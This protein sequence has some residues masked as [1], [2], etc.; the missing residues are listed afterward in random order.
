M[1]LLV[2]FTIPI[3]IWHFTVFVPDRFWGGIIGAFVAA[4]VGGVATGV[5]GQVLSGDPLSTT[6]IDTVLWTVPG[7]LAALAIAYAI[8]ARQVEREE[9]EAEALL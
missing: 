6:G 3:A 2:W 1:A 5:L 9:A 4:I 7:T 8:G